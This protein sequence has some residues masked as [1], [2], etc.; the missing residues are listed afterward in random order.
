MRF[1]PFKLVV[2]D[3]AHHIAAASYLKI[4]DAARAV[5]PECLIFGL[6]ATPER[7]DSKS[8]RKVFSNIA[9]QITLG[10]LI[11]AGNLVTPRCFVIDIGTQ[12]ALS[13]VK[14]T[15]ADFD[16]GQVAQ[17]MDKEPLTDRV[18]SEWAKVAHDRKT[19]AFASTVEH[20]QHV[21]AAFVAAGYRAAVVSGE[22]PDAERGALLRALDRGDLQIV[23]NCAV[24]TEG[25][26]SQPVSCIVLLRPSSH[27]STF[28]QMVGRGLRTV[29]PELY[30][31]VTKSDCL[32]L[33]FGTSVLT[34]GSLEQEARLGHGEIHKHDAPKKVCPECQALVPAGCF[35][36]GFCGFV[37]IVVDDLTG[38]T[39][40]VLTDFVLS[41]V[42]ILNSSPFKWEDI[43]DGLVSV[44]DAFDAWAMNV[45]FNA[46]WNAIGGSKE[47]GIRLLQRG[48]RLLCLAAADDFLREHGDA[49]G[50]R[51]SKSW[52]RAPAT[53]KQLTYLGL[54]PME[55][56]GLTKYRAAA[57]LTFKF[58]ERGIQRKLMDQNPLPT[59]SKV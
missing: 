27:R 51:K 3:E 20:A 30:P 21:S 40:D 11:R 47:Y 29:D 31:G 41:E 12:D 39:R 14:K 36:C 56:L 48:E 6:T 13:H 18:V 24:L 42:D 8:L 28:I 15:A 2:V 22:T 23:V 55:G 9:D 50:A 45:Y 34:H 58:N 59:M 4:I 33:D 1:N 57:F 52:L 19:I 44:A 43:H 17:I 49:S 32:V 10:E 25:F 35:E 16:M 53:A 37:F 26:D 5:N 38:V 54:S 7:G 46:T